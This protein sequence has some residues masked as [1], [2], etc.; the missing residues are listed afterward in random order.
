VAVPWEI[1]AHDPATAKLATERWLKR[2]G[3]AA[4]RRM[5]EGKGTMA[6][7]EK[8]A[9]IFNGGPAGHKRQS[10]LAYAAKVRAALTKEKK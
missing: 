8:L 5:A 1:G 7:A 6:D 10:T 9:R 3:G 4:A 2:Y